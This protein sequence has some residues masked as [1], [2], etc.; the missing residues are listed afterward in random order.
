MKLNSH[1]MALAC[2]QRQTSNCI[3]AAKK[4]QKMSFGSTKNIIQSKA[5]NMAQKQFKGNTFPNS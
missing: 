5:E 4:K 1:E 2:H 3:L